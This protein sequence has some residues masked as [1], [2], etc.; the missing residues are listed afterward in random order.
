MGWNPVAVILFETFFFPIHLDLKLTYEKILPK[1]CLLLLK[2]ASFTEVIWA[3]K[4]IFFSVLRLLD[5]LLTLTSITLTESSCLATAHGSSRFVHERL[6]FYL[7]SPEG[8]QNQRKLSLLLFW[9]TSRGK[10]LKSVM[11]NLRHLC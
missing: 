10:Y 3:V 9:C 7:W 2:K 5:Y 4:T 6:T 1:I 8:R 11:H